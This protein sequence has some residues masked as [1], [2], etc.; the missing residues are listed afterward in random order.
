MIHIKVGLA[1][2]I[3]DGY[4]GEPADS[5]GFDISIDGTNRRYTR[6]PGGFFAFT[7]LDPGSHEL[8]IKNPFY[9]TEKMSFTSSTELLPVVLKPAPNYPYGRD[10]SRIS[11]KCCSDT[12][13]KLWIGQIREDMEIKIAQSGLKAGDSELRLY[14]EG[15]AEKLSFPGYC[16]ISDGENSEIVM[17]DALKKDENSFT[18]EPLKSAHKRGCC[19]YPVLSYMSEPGKSIDVTFKEKSD[20]CVWIPE[21]KKLAVV[22]MDNEEY[23]V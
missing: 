12:P 2:R 18:G 13:V 23:T 5:V 3:T 6:K 7:G 16:L 22:N 17:L 10:A 14:Y 15:K 20:V 4:T 9:I 8:I 21:L 19:L 11:L 1:L